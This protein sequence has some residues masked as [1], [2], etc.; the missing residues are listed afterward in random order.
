[1]EENRLGPG[2]LM[3]LDALLAMPQPMAE[4]A[5]RERAVPFPLGPDR[6]QSRIL[7]Q[8]KFFVHPGDLGFGAHVLGD[9]YWEIWLTLFMARL[10]QPGWTV[11]DVGA[12]FGYYTVLMADRVGPGGR[13][14]AYEPN[15]VAAR[16]LDDTVEIN[17]FSGR[18]TIRRAAASDA[19]RGSSTFFVPDREPKNARV[20]PSDFRPVTP[21]LLLEVPERRIDDD[22]HGREPVHFIKIDAEGLEGQ[23]LAGAAG[24]IARD[25]P[26]MVVEFN[27]RRGDAWGTLEFLLNHYGSLSI[28]DFDGQARKTALKT[29]LSENVGEDWLVYVGPEPSNPAP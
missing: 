23:I 2:N 11:L 16:F 5:M 7:G 13:V 12:N 6:M 4:A 20:V 29:L 22:F 19:T 21:G 28:V 18:T 27:A 14:H 9:G 15:P 10:I 17:G 3:T 26:H 24:L 8:Y 25:R 1:M